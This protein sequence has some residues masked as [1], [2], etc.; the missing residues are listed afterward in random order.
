MIFYHT[1]VEIASHFNKSYSLIQPFFYYISTYIIN[2]TNINAD[3]N[4]N[5]FKLFYRKVLKSAGIS[6]KIIKEHID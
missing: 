5:F 4:G 2:I 6:V 3:F 1:P